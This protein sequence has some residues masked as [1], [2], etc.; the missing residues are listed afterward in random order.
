MSAG[1][2]YLRMPIGATDLSAT[3]Y[4]YDDTSGDTDLSDFSIDVVP[5]Y[6]FEVLNDIIAVNPRIKVHLC[7]WSPVRLLLSY[8]SVSLSVLFRRF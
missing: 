7:P 2:T 8:L 6:V 5:A 1:L 4:T 3:A